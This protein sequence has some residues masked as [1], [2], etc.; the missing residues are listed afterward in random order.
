[1]KTTSNYR[2]LGIPRNTNSHNLVMTSLQRAIANRLPQQFNKCVACE[3]TVKGPSSDIE[4]DCFDP[5][6]TEQV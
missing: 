2:G 6:N 3:V 5:K 4:P 1:M